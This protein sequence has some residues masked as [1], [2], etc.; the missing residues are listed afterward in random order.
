MNLNKDQTLTDILTLN[1]SDPYLILLRINEDIIQTIRFIMK[2]LLLVAHGSRRKQSNDEVKL[3]AE[4]LKNNCA[5]Q[6]DIVNASF[7]ELADVLIPEGIKQCI[8]E[9]AS[10]IVVLPYFLN[11]GV[12][13]T[14]DIPNEVNQCLSQYPETDISV[15]AHL[16]A[17]SLMMDLLISSASN[18]KSLSTSIST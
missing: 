5:E 14:Q 7:L 1:D 6:Y 16:G 15:A 13:V 4:K 11:S 9:G 12:H 8:D 2:A 17:S 3:L 10:S 18:A